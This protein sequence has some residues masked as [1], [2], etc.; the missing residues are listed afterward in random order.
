MTLRGAL[1]LFV[2]VVLGLGLALSTSVW[3]ALTTRQKI[4]SAADP[5][6]ESAAMIAEVIDRVRR[7]YVDRI[8]D[9]RIVESAIR[10]IVSDLDQHSSFLNEE[11][12]E[13]IRITTSGNYTGIGLDV[14]LEGG[15]V[16]VVNPLEGAPAARAGIMPGDVV[17]SVDDMPVDEKDVGA[18][19]A[20]MRGAPGTP[21]TLDV[22]RAGAQEPLRFALTRSAV[23]VKSVTGEYLGNGLAYVR[24]SSFT[25]STPRDLDATVRELT[26]NAGIDHLL[27]IVLDLRGNP[28]GVLDAAV[29]VADEF[30]ADGLI[31]S[32]T[33]RVQQARFQQ[34]AHPG[35]VLEGVPAVVLVNRGSASASEIV[36]GALKDHHRA[37]IVGETTYGKG[38]VQT[39]MPLGEGM[40]IKLTTS[41]YLTPSGRSINGS[42]IEPDVVVHNADQNRQ[43]HGAGGSVALRDDTQLFEALRLISYDSIAQTATP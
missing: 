13:A 25:D 6:I 36:A 41:R 4:P 19:V 12:Y 40:A 37:R 5:T 8:D 1:V 20:R 15:K 34:F 30:L 38:S 2:G 32:G 23:Q 3:T 24:L 21:V 11:Q 18:T 43:Y 33:G 42:G 35:D 14:N 31:V 16:T 39:V 27:G 9:K 22:V 10:G 29:R 17:V 7:E 28:G 26:A